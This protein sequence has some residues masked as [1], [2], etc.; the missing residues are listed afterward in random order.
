MVKVQ[1]KQPLQAITPI[2]S[3]H[4]QA[5]LWILSGIALICGCSTWLHKRV[6]A[7]QLKRLQVGL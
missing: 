7:R 1:T 3:D 4:D 5:R 2:M 6:T